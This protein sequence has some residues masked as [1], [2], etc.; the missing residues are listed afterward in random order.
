MG[1]NFVTWPRSEE[2]RLVLMGLVEKEWIDT[3]TTVD[4]QE[5]IYTDYVVYAQELAK[6]LEAKNVDFVIALT[7]MRW[8]NDIRLAQ[9]VPE[10]DMILEG[11]DHEYGVKDISGRAFREEMQPILGLD[12]KINSV[13]LYAGTDLQLASVFFFYVNI[14]LCK[15]C[16]VNNIASYGCGRT[17]WC[18]FFPA[19]SNI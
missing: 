11:H 12:L 9:L 10:I 3:L 5:L 13:R 2:A 4:E 15:R 18:E 17:L 1:L 19:Y 8:P 6:T 7:H 16:S 14:F